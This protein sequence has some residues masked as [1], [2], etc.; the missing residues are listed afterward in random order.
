MRL[1]RTRRKAE[2][3]EILEG[4]S[5]VEHAS[6]QAPLDREV[7]EG[8][9]PSPPVNNNQPWESPLESITEV[10]QL[11]SRLKRFCTGGAHTRKVKEELHEAGIVRL[12]Y[13]FQ[14]RKGWR[15]KK[16]SSPHH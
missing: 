6:G 9:N 8:S 4:S 1:S 2:F 7:V 10:R 12:P 16:Q 14:R 13:R 5:E 11:V 15:K 3:E